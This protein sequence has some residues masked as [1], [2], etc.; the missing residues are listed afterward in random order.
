MT[1]DRALQ[2]F[3]STNKTS[4]NS[5]LDDAIKNRK[6]LSLMID[7]Y[8]TIHTTRRPKDLKTSQAK[9]MC[10]MIFISISSY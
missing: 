2:N 8:T 5:D 10:T 4:V 6:L 7:D 1:V 3:S 9:N